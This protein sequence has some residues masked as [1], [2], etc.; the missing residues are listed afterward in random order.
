MGVKA[1]AIDLDNTTVNDASFRLPEQI[2]R[3]I[4]RVQAAG[5]QVIIVSNTVTPRAWFL[6]KK[7]GGVPFVANARKPRTKAL[8]RAAR[9]LNLHPSEIAMIGDQLFT[10]VLVANRVGAISV[11]VDPIGRDKF[12]PKK[13]E[14][15]RR[16]EREYIQKCIVPNGT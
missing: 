2:R 10:D 15:I 5:I 11:K 8:Y 14:E 4:K 6:S 13:Y 16:R 12:T 9:K 3:W 1:V 7:M